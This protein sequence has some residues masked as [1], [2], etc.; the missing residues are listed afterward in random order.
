MREGTKLPAPARFIWKEETQALTL[1]GELVLTVRLRWPEPEMPGAGPRRLGRYH[2]QVAQ[3]WRLRWTRTLYLLA[4]LD[5]AQRRESSRPFQPWSAQLDG[6]WALLPGGLWSVRSEAR[7]VRGDGRATVVRQC[8]LWRLYDGAPVPP[9]ALL[10][11]R[12]RRRQLL[13]RAAEVAQAKQAEGTLFLR[14][15]WQA[16]LRTICSPRRLEVTAD[17]LTLHCPQCT[18]A[19]GAEGVVALPLG[20][21]PP[22]AP[23]LRPPQEE[24]A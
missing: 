12:A 3:Q 21:D 13:A 7:E 6:D 5:L 15:G 20:W 4:S 9:S 1:G 17:G 23:A 2:A 14:E 11:G 22:A 10:S 16:Q 8:D 18:I 24:L 19:P